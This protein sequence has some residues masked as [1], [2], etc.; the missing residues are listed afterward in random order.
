MNKKGF[1][2]IECTIY[3]CILMILSAIT[4]TFIARVTTAIG[5][6]NARM[7]KGVWLDAAHDLLRF[8]LQQGSALLHDWHQVQGLII[9]KGAQ[10]CYGWILKGENL[11]RM[12][13]SYDFNAQRWLNKSESLVAR[14]IQTL[15]MQLVLEDGLVRAVSYSLTFKKGSTDTRTIYLINGAC[16]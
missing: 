8:D 3:A 13:G 2:L 1:S 12:K 15:S 16:V 6:S 11:Y 10:E 14:F 4:F 9:G 7:Q 5:N